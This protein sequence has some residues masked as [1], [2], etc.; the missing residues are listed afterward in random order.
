MQSDLIRRIRWGN[1]AF[2]VA[3]LVVAARLL[4]IVFGAAPLP[5]L[6]SDRPAPLITGAEVSARLA[7]DDAPPGTQAKPTRR[8]RAARRRQHRK[9]APK[10]HRSPPAKRATA[11]VATSAPAA[12]PQP[13]AIAPA[14]PTAPRA[15]AAGRGE[16]GFEGG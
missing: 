7:P 11:N 16:F 4:G 13:A 6:P 3:A 10:R 12:T 8:P 2:A 5:R 14:R 9:P 1:L 15:S